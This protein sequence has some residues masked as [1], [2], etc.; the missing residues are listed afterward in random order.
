MTCAVKFARGLRSGKILVDGV[1]VWPPPSPPPPH[2]QIHLRCGKVLVDGT[3]A[4]VR[5]EFISPDVLQYVFEWLD[6]ADRHAARRVSR[7]FGSLAGIAELFLPPGAHRDPLFNLEKMDQ[8]CVGGCSH[9]HEPTCSTVIKA[10]RYFLT[11]FVR[12]RPASHVATF[13]RN[14]FGRTQ[15]R[16]AMLARPLQRA[17]ARG[18]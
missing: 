3:Y 11:V 9:V 13:P 7:L 1:Y 18:K 17:R 2:T 4:Q 10:T 16:A 15:A 12:R 8:C 5:R 6:L 14:H